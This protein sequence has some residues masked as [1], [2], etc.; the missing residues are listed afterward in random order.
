MRLS[1]SVGLGIR[2]VATFV[3]AMCAAGAASAQEASDELWPQRVFTVAGRRGL[4]QGLE[5]SG[6][7]RLALR[8]T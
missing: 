3:L 4:E 8:C 5:G 7:F 1:Q 2:V 6:I